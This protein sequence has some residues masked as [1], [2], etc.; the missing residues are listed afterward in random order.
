MSAWSGFTAT[1][2]L[3]ILDKRGFTATID[4]ANI[5]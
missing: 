2:D 3:A 4:L 5:R 1:I